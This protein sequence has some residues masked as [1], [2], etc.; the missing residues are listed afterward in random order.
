MA[1][2]KNLQIFIL[3]SLLAQ[4]VNIIQFSYLILRYSRNKYIHTMYCFD[5]NEWKSQMPLK[6]SFSFISFKTINSISVFPLRVLPYSIW[7]PC[8]LKSKQIVSLHNGLKFN[9]MTYYRSMMLSEQTTLEVHCW[10]PLIL[11]QGVS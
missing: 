7:N 6:I 3:I 2:T 9:N 4:N 5:G 11:V 10:L 1:H 8:E